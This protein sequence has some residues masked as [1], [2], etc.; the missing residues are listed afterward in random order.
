MKHLTVTA[1]KIICRDPQDPK[2]DEIYF[3]TA[4][5][6]KGRVSEGVRGVT[7]GSVVEEDIVLIDDEVDERSPLLVTAVEQR[8]ARDSGMLA[9]MLEEIAGRGADIARQWLKENPQNWPAYAAMLGSYL[10]DS[11][12]GTV[13]LLFRDTPLL[14]KAIPDPYAD[15]VEYPVSY[16]I[17][18]RSDERPTYD[19]EI[20]LEVCYR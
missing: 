4:V 8:A 11:V 7:R 16:V 13:K 2:R 10:M 1:K 14:V 17:K 15:D 5:A 19:Y 9:G 6:G 20:L 3:V 18:G 12:V